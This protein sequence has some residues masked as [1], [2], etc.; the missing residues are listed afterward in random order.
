MILPRQKARWPEAIRRIAKD[1]DGNPGGNY[2]N[3]DL[4]YGRIRIACGMF[5]H[6]KEYMARGLQQVYTWDANIFEDGGTSYIAKQNESPG[7]H[8]ACI[9]LAYDSYIMTRDPKI[10]DMLKKL[11]IIRSPSP[12]RISPPSGTPS[13]PGS[14]R[15]MEREPG[16]PIAS[17]IISPETHTTSC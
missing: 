9:D 5:L 14:N 2:S 8:G 11:D 4:G 6:D 17:S 10:T 15:G 7:Y 13:H 3:A 12:I 1:H 16:G